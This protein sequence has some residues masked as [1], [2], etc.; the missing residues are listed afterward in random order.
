M[1]TM[2]RDAAG[3]QHHSIAFSP[4]G[5]AVTAGS[6][7]PVA[8]SA[9]VHGPGHDSASALHPTPAHGQRTVLRQAPDTADSELARTR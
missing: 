3:Q 6:R 2:R 4:D 8:E 5:Q 1:A 9:P 7:L